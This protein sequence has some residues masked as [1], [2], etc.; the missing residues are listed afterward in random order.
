MSS[1][2]RYRFQ[3]SLTLTAGIPQ[4]LTEGSSLPGCCH[5]NGWSTLKPVRW[6]T[7]A[8]RPERP[9]AYANGQRV[10]NEAA[11]ILSTITRGQMTNQ[12]QVLML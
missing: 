12:F 6:P 10:V 9:L 1:D 11:C 2:D 3:H 5:W 7:S 8:R 4:S